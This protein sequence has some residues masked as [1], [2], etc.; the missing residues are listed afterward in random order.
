MPATSY[1]RAYLASCLQHSTQI[2]LRW[3]LD[4]PETLGMI[5]FRYLI[6]MK[7]FLKNI[8]LLDNKIIIKEV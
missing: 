6:K 2:Q 5:D 7:I 1:N 4:T 3:T 8:L